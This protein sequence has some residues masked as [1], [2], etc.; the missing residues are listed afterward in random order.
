VCD[1]GTNDQPL[2]SIV[3]DAAQFR[4]FFD[5]DQC[6]G[7]IQPLLHQN[8][9]MRAAG[10]DLCFAAVLLEQRAGF[11][12]RRW[13]EVVE[14]SHGSLFSLLFKVPGSKFKVFRTTH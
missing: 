3:L 1:Q 6:P 14:I 13:F 12:D 10:K 2:G 4:N 11:S 8:R 7:L 9:E 5:V